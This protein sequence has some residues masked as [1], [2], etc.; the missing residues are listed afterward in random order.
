MSFIIF[1]P[2]YE[3]SDRNELSKRGLDAIAKDKQP[4]FRPATFP[5]VG[6][7]TL[8]TLGGLTDIPASTIDLDE[9]TWQE[10]AR[11]GELEAGRYW[12]GYV[13][14][15]KPG[16]VDCVR[17]NVIDGAPITLRDGNQWVIPSTQF[18]PSAW[19]INSQT[20][21]DER[22]I[23]D[24]HREFIDRANE[25]FRTLMSD[26]FA[27]L[28]DEKQIVF[29]PSGLTFAASALAQNYRVNRNVVA[30]LDLIG[31]FEAWEIVKAVLGWP[32]FQSMLE[33]K[34]TEDTFSHELANS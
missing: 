33:Q 27:Q 6:K 9:Q 24:E 1:L 8:V 5:D 19:T 25:M 14:S 17:R 4:F 26:H 3:G 20:G 2:G 7:G 32:Q 34:K 11:E 29:V 16:P 10:A 18:I 15:R 30:L 12:I 28:L 31:D 21:E 13:N 22:V 23:A